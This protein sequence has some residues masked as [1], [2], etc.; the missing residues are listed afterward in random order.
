MT[1]WHDEKNNEENV[2]SPGCAKM[3][4]RQLKVSVISMC[5]EESGN[6]YWLQDLNNC[7]AFYREVMV[8]LPGQD[9]QSTLM[10]PNSVELRRIDRDFQK[11][12]EDVF[13]GALAFTS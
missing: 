7:F 12:A 5:P 11:I 2:T 9:Q 3:D 4:P 6:S 8:N 13:V 1:T 10:N